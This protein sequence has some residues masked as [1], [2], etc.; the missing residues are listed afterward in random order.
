MA[1]KIL[2]YD[3]DTLSADGS[4]NLTQT[5]R[6]LLNEYPFLSRRDIIEFQVLDTTKG[7]AMFPNPSV[8]ILT[9]KEDVIGHVTQTCAY[10]FTVVYRT[11]STNKEY[12]KEWLDNLG[13]WLEK[14]AI[15]KDDYEYK[16][17]RYPALAEG[18]EFIK[19]ARST[20]SYLYGTTEDKA[21]DWAISMQATYRNE[22]DR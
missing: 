5:L 8:A 18:K 14:Q 10:A 11:R 7:I 21:D 9:E 12:V 20:Q 19:I 6:N 1:G 13:R 15:N 3:F 22:F 4:D 17:E 2:R 16:L